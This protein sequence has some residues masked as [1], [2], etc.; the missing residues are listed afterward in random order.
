[1]DEDIVAIV[2]IG[3]ILF[4]PVAG[5]TLRFALK[6]VV[7]AM[8]RMIDRR[9]DSDA[10]ALIE[11][12]MNLFEQELSAMRGDLDRMADRAEFYDSLAEERLAGKLPSGGEGH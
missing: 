6:P 3:L 2:V 12:R 8:A 4:T 9:A 7:D 11:R 1:M 10:T 5:F